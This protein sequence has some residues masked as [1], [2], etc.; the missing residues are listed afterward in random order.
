MKERTNEYGTLAERRESSTKRSSRPTNPPQVKGGNNRTNTSHSSLTSD[1][2]ERHPGGELIIRLE[3]AAP[4]DSHQQLSPS[5]G[6]DQSRTI[7][8]ID[9]DRRES[10]LSS[11]D[12]D[13]DLQRSREKVNPYSYHIGV[14]GFFKRVIQL[15]VNRRCRRALLSASVAMISQQLTGINTIA[16]LG[17]TV[18]EKSLFTTGPTD[19]YHSARIAAIIG[20]AFGAANYLFGLP[21]YWLSDKVGRSVMLVIGLPNLAWLMLVFAFCFKVKDSAQIP[22]VSVFAVLFTM[23]YAPT[24]GTSP[25]SI[26]AEVFPLGTSIPL[27]RLLKRILTLSSIKRGWHGSVSC[28]ESS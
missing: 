15:W 22:L 19:P 27:P 17:T 11:L 28:C 2:T 24:A 5:D 8:L 18:W 7:E 3:P 26:S 12:I 21:A 9:L 20:L 4:R 6:Q 25:F 23:V 14:T 16:F 10:A 1:T 13:L